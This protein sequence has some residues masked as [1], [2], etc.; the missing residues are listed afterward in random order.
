MPRDQLVAET[1]QSADRGGRG[2]K[3]VHLVLGNH[4]PEAVACG[5]GGD[6]LKHQGPGADGE[7]TVDD[8]GVASDPAD[9]SGAPVGFTVAIVEHILHRH[10]RLEQ[11]ATRRMQDAFGFTRGAGGVE[12]EQRVLAVHPLGLTVITDRGGGVVEPDVPAVD[13]VGLAPCTSDHDN[14]INAVDLRQR[15][16]DVAF[17][18][19][20][21]ATTDALIGGDHHAACCVIDAIFECFGGEPTEDDRVDGTYSR[22][23]EHGERRFGNHR[24]VDTDTVALADSLCSQRIRESTHLNLELLIGKRLAVIGVVPLPDNGGV[25]RAFWQMPVNAVDRDVQFCV[26][27]PAS[28]ALGDVGL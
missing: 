4:L 5:I 15:R 17:E 21:F 14:A 25:M 7:R 11:V 13:P 3:Q 12:D 24:H 6:P 8:I 23:G 26:D 1:M 28:S 27:K 22:A 10:G 9:V 16:V 19:Y 18:R 20:G 2:E